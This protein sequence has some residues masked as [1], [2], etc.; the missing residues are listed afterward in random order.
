MGLIF[1]VVLDFLTLKHGRQGGAALVGASLIDNGRQDGAIVVT[2]TAAK[3]GSTTGRNDG[4]LAIVMATVR[5]LEFGIFG[6]RVANGNLSF[7]P[8]QQGS[9]VILRKVTLV[10][11]IQ[12][13]SA[14]GV[15][16]ARRR[17]TTS[18]H[19]ELNRLALGNGS[20]F[21]IRH[22]GLDGRP[23][24]AGFVVRHGTPSLRGLTILVA[25][26]DRSTRAAGS[27]GRARDGG[28]RRGV[29]A[30]VQGRIEGFAQA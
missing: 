25:H 24:L 14:T 8:G 1:I 5:T 28:V 7:G 30:F 15:G 10:R 20:H 3:G 26:V 4:T 21:F 12:R 22:N 27:L 2:N 18:V 13:G 9:L 16:C 11:G 23:P 19:E 6:P 17:L 29:V